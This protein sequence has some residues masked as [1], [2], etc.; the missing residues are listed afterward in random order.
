M[1]FLPKHLLSLICFLLSGE[2]GMEAKIIFLGTGGD[3]IVIG[4]QLRSSGGFILQMGDVQFHVDPGPGALLRARQE[5][6][7]LR[8]N[9]ALFVSHA[10]L[11]HCND[12]NAVISAMT[13][14][15]LDKTGVLVGNKTVLEG[16]EE[17]KPYVTDF[18]K[19]CVERF[20][21]LEQNAKIGI[22]DIDIKTL[23]AKHSDPDTLGF[24]FLTPDFTL[25]YSS[26]TEY[27][28]E[29]IEA[30]K[31]SDILILNIVNPSG[32]K[33]KGLLNSDDA[34]KII[35]KVKPTLAI[36]QHFGIKMLTVNPLTEAREIGKK[37]N[38]Q[39]I[40]AKEGL[41]VNPLSYS[42]KAKQKT[43]NSFK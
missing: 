28:T 11:N 5:D 4:K 40:A 3:S 23:Y 7:N 1:L 34:V 32:I 20:I 29:L 17:I 36:I 25:S 39:T 43:L 21:S 13:H 30:Y 38:V 35:N 9:T 15:G 24:K 31:N 8:E 42:A 14:A 19:S 2:K 37:T 22:N 33:Q 27:S 12:V 16:S 26:D 6:V 18:H 41:V 10:H